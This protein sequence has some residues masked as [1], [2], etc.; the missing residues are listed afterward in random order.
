MKKSLQFKLSIWLCTAIIIIAFAGG[1]FSFYTAFE[2]ANEMQDDQLRQVA[3]LFKSHA[4]QLTPPESRETVPAPNLEFRVLVEVIGASGVDVLGVTQAPLMLP[5]DM[6]E[7]MRT[8]VVQQEPWRVFVT[9][10]DSERQ[11]VVAQKVAIREEVAG[12]SATATLIPYALLIPVLLIIV[13]YLIRQMFKPVT[14]LASELDQ[15]P[16]QD[17]RPV[18]KKDLPTEIVPFVASINRMLVRVDLSIAQQRRFIADAAHEM[19]TP[20]TALSLQ[21]ERLAAS[22]MSDQARERLAKLRSGLERTG[23]LLNQLLAFARAQQNKIEE[24]SAVSVRRVFH[25]VLEDLMPLAQAKKI[26]I[27]VVGEQDL[28]VQVQEFDLIALLKNLVD[29]SIRYTPDG[30]KIDLAIFARDGRSGIVVEDNGPGIPESER[31]RVFDPFYRVLG[32]D[33]TGSGLGLSIVKLCAERMGAEVLLGDA[34]A[35]KEN[36]GLRVEVLFR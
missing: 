35:S 25:S 15:R 18:E 30:G 3:T 33:E 22:E 17:L 8:L 9:K 6:E 4:A 1:A 19:R 29:N 7:G 14:K 36:P 2:E 28:I 31:E 21:A 13:S 12:E 5:A 26:D 32:N 27:G 23:L 10:L 34:H 24:A 20:L 16:E 11:L